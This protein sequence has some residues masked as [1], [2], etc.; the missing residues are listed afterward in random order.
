[1]EQPADLFLRRTEQHFSARLYDLAFD[2]FAIVQYWHP[3]ASGADR[4]RLFEKILCRYCE[5]KQL[6][7]SERPG[8]R[9]IRGV[10]AASGFMHEND[11]VLAFPDFT[12]HFEL[13]HL[14]DH[15]GKNELLI[16]NQ[17]SLDFLAAE[18]ARLRRLPLYRIL[19]SGGLLNDSA[20]RF[21]IQ[22]GIMVIEPDRFPFLPLHWCAG[23]AV[24][25]LCYVSLAEQDDLWDE[26]PYLIAPIQD[27]ITRFA[28]LLA[29][30]EPVV[31][32]HRVDWAINHM[33][34]QVGDHYWNALDEL[35]PTWLEHRFD[36]VCELV[37]LS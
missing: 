36:D 11:A 23:R 24:N 13:K 26:V 32:S 5:A 29:T 7:M 10:R 14:T 28:K 3:D 22:W 25:N 35:D 2:L 15:L 27:R 8:S 16:F 12:V 33:Q 30:D 21:A 19:L 1:M 18:S 34:R 31:G 17:K 20:R 4:G 6:P 37:H 9:T